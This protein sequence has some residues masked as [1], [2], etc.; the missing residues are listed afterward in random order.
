MLFK[1]RS[2]VRNVL[3]R[4]LKGGYFCI[5]GHGTRLIL[6]WNDV[7]K[8]DDSKEKRDDT[9]PTTNLVLFKHFM[10]SMDNTAREVNCGL[11]R[12]ERRKS[13]S[14]SLSSGGENGR[15]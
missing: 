1:N 12:E 3:R 15:V 14:L 7:A 9:P 4:Q 2:A 10:M 8:D 13:G 6:E 11:V 5:F